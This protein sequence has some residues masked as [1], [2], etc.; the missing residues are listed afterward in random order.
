MFLN[1]AVGGM[2]TSLRADVVDPNGVVWSDHSFDKADVVGQIVGE[3]VLD[4]LDD[5]EPVD[6]TDLWFRVD[7]IELPV[8]NTGFQAMFI[9]GVL[10]HRST[11]HYDPAEPIDDD[12]LPW[13][14]TEVDLLG[15]GPLRLLTIP[16]EPLP[17]LAIGGYDGAYT[18]VDHDIVDLTEPNAPD[19]SQGPAGP[20]WHDLMGGGHTWVI[21]LANDE[22]GYIIPEYNFVVADAGAYIFEAE[23]HHYEETN[24]LGPQT[25]GLITESV[26]RL[27]AW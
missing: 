18:P 19:V 12:N 20:Y 2:M 9:L 14:A 5:A 26:E 4:G 25:A 11:L 6:W 23:G 16:G 7:S 1:G 10:D 17:E 3:M 27:T 15:L 13:V 24:S 8:D 22:I 21:G